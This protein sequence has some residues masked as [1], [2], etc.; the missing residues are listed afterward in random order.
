[1]SVTLRVATLGLPTHRKQEPM[2]SC[3]W[4]GCI[5][6]KTRCHTKQDAHLQELVYVDDNL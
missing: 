2:R 3:F 6:Q 1:M 5:Y 4:D